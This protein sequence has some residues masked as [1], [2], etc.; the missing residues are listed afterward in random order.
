MPSFRPR[1]DVP[2][3]MAV[4]L[5]ASGAGTTRRAHEESPARSTRR[6]LNPETRYRRPCL[7]E[8]HAARRRNAL[9]Q[10]VELCACLHAPADAFCARAAV[11]MKLMVDASSE[12]SGWPRRKPSTCH[13]LL[14]VA[15]LQQCNVRSF[16]QVAESTDPRSCPYRRNLAIGEMRDK[17]YASSHSISLLAR[18]AT[19]VH[20]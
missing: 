9:H 14:N 10:G 19:A 6:R 2:D 15:W 1:G 4:C 12:S 11:R 7:T 18:L 13:Q 16:G 8:C 20:S 3:K 17:K 5:G